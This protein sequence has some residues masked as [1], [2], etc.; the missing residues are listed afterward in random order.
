M[1]ANIDH[2]DDGRINFRE[3]VLSVWKYVVLGKHDIAG[4]AFDMYDTDNSGN[5][6][7]LCMDFNTDINYDVD[8]GS[9]LKTR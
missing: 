4:F 3:F 7:T 8:Q 1:F 6:Y 5:A 9:C 2:N